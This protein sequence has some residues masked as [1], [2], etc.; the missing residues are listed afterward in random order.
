MKLNF[1]Q[2][3]GVIL[4]VMGIA[5]VIY[6][7]TRKEAPAGTAAPAPTVN[8]PLNAPTTPHA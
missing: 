2:I 8:V 4:I 1:W 7:E 3:L 5:Y 6:R